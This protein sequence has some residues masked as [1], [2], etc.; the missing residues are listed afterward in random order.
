MDPREVGIQLR[1]AAAQF[2]VTADIGRNLRFIRR[3]VRLAAGRG[4]QV[5]HFPKGA[6]SGDAPAHDRVPHETLGWCDEP[7]EP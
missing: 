4:A 2:P 1:V 7:E 5:V 3:Q 6:L